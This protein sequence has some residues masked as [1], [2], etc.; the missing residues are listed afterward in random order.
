MNRLTIRCFGRPLTWAAMWLG[1]FTAQGDDPL[2]VEAVQT[3]AGGILIVGD[4]SC[5]GPGVD[6]PRQLAP[7][8]A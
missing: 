1:A 3:N 7:G 6:S 5:H 8:R 4:G 2:V